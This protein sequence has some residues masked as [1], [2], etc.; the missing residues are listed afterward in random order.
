MFSFSI[1]G[2]YPNPF[3]W[4]TGLQ[5]FVLLMRTCLPCWMLHILKSPLWRSDSREKL[6]EVPCVFLVLKVAGLW[7]SRSLFTC[8]TSNE[9]EPIIFWISLWYC[10]SVDSK[11]TTSSEESKWR[12][13][14][15]SSP[16][17]GSVLPLRIWGKLPR[18]KQPERLV[19]GEVVTRDFPS[20]YPR[21]DNHTQ[22]SLRETMGW[23]SALPGVVW[24]ER[25]IFQ[26]NLFQKFASGQTQEDAFALQKMLIW[27]NC[28]TVQNKKPHR[29][30]FF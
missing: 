27:E 21:K 19:S 22:T 28:K 15:S 17:L 13:T 25:T 24:Q 12:Q 26:K 20:V 16:F 3:L 18:K 23:A 30:M 2:L 4:F 29:T 1:S 5:C 11:E 6:T 10:L 9:F 14:S 7:P 8:Q